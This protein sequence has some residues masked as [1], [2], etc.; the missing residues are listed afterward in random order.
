MSGRAW[1]QNSTRGRLGIGVANSTDYLTPQIMD[2]SVS[3]VEFA[4]I[5]SN[6]AIGRTDTGL[7]YAWGSNSSAQLGNG[8][9]DVLAHATPVQVP[10]LTNIV[11]IR[12]GTLDAN[13]F[14]LDNLGNLYA[15]GDQFGGEFGI[16]STTQQSSPVLVNTGVVDVAVGSQHS[17][18]LK[19]GGVVQTAGA[20]GRG[21]LGT[22]NTTNQ[23]TWQTVTPAGTVT[24][25]RAGDETTVMLF[26][27]GSVAGWGYSQSGQL[28]NTNATNLTLVT[29]PISNAI[30]IG[31]GGRHFYFL[32]ADLTVWAIGDNRSSVLGVGLNQ[33]ALA[34]STTAIQQTWPVGVYPTMFGAAPNSGVI[35]ATAV[36]S[37]RQMYVWGD[38][39]FGQ[40]GNNTTTGEVSTPTNATGLLTVT[41]CGG[42]LG[43]F[44][45]VSDS[46]GRSS[47]QFVG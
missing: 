31:E 14:A 17:V 11:K 13:G 12:A 15:W 30:E 46:F 16:G 25:V 21:K 3:F 41:A 2:S 18:V 29:V 20:G 1:G 35:S 27:D 23:S 5:A 24:A 42:E 34:S 6:G 38:N 43:V 10:G 22:G 40:Q 8:T 4:T 45:N 47:V 7:V 19:T 44:A 36:G 33:A 9:T 32:L 39:T 26:A 37:D 28:G